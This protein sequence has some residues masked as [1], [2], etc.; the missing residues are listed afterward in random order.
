MFAFLCEAA[1]GYRFNCERIQLKLLKNCG[2]V[3]FVLLAAKAECVMCRE[4]LEIAV[5]D[6]L[7]FFILLDVIH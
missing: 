1:N 2:G 6:Q 7:L 4:C 5:D 3:L